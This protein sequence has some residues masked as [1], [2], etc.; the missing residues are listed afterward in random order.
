MGDRD[1]R[2]PITLLVPGPWPDCAPVESALAELPALVEWIPNDGRFVEAFSFGRY[3]KSELDRVDACTG[4]ALVTLRLDRGR[5]GQVLLD[6]ATRL[7][8][9]GAYGVRIEDSKGAWGLDA[10]IEALT[11][12][13]P[14]ATLHAV[15]VLAVGHD[16]VYTSGLQVFGLPD[17]LMVA[18]ADPQ[19]AARFLSMLAQYQLIE[20]PILLSGQ[21]F[22][23]DAETPR[24]TLERW[25]DHRFP[26]SAPCHNPFGIWRVGPPALPGRQVPKLVAVAVPAFVVTLVA[27]ERKAGRAL[28]RAEVNDAVR[29]APVI[30]MEHRDA[31]ALERSRG[32]S[33]IDPELAWEQWQVVRSTL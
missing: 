28:T 26:Q 15:M 1:P 27:L 2:R 20:E 31:L 21:T 32:Y 14:F 23:P 17:A 3:P 10:W 16:E 5:E 25:P 12:P 8:R 11:P 24:Q 30:A 13:T 7:A 9:S 29:K 18:G 4:A 33:D 6:T 19:G 22:A